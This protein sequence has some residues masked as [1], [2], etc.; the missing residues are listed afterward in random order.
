MI[1]VCTDIEN[2]GDKSMWFFMEGKYIRRDL[3]GEIKGQITGKH[4][5]NPVELWKSRCA[6]T[7]GVFPAET[8]AHPA[9]GEAIRLKP[10]EAVFRLY[11]DW[12]KRKDAQ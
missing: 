1:P 6:E 8:V 12:G 7:G 5:P 11:E 9:T 2:N 10:T 3:K 4:L